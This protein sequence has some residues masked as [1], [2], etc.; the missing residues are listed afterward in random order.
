MEK[1]DK[2]WRK[3][4]F[5]FYALAHND[6]KHFDELEPELQDT[7]VGRLCAAYIESKDYELIDQ[8]GR[9]LTGSRHW[10]TYLGR[11]M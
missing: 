7:Q 2:D 11:S 3:L 8:A 5:A 10:Y 9:L 6:P 1:G 4:A